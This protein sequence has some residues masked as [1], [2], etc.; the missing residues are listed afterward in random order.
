MM[1]IAVAGASGRMGL[2][3]IKA[4][5]LTDKAGLVAAV[6]RPGSDAVGKDAGELAGIGALGVKV[7]DNLTAVVDQFDVVIDFTRPEASM[8]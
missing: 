5:T 3:L 4:A 7:V 8:A 6:S 2:C 1:R